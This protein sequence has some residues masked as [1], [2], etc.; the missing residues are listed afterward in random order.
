M[1][2]T[3]GYLIFAVALPTMLHAFDRDSAGP[4]LA[5]TSEEASKEIVAMQIR[6]QGYRCSRAV[7]A[8][9][10]VEHA[11]TKGGWILKCEEATYHIH[12]V[13]RRAA[14]VEQVQ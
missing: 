6:K 13:P 10:D 5:E 14:H 4:Q 8:D 9:R 2:T 12:L 1:K 3:N 7:S 11:K